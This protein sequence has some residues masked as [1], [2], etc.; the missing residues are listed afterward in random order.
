MN[1]TATTV[2]D[3][4]VS[5]AV[6]ANDSDL[7]GDTLTV[8]AIGAA[9][10]GAAAVNPDGT[11][12]FTPAANY[13]GSDDF[14]YAI[15]DGNGG[16]ASATVIMTITTSNDAPMAVGDSYTTAE[17]TPLTPVTRVLA[18]DSDA[19]QDHLTAVLVE[20]PSRGTLTLN[21]DGSFTYTP[22]ANVSGV[23]TFRYR[24]TTG[25]PTPIR[26]SSPSP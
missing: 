20:G 23:D 3:A 7:D 17:D 25:Q 6:L 22:N 14:T 9:A 8:T 19:D 11:I 10:H 2:E 15:A 4:S 26:H 18:N 16:S 5:I 13:Y 1:D 24:R 21:A 12:A